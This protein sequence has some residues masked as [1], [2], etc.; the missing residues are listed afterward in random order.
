MCVTSTKTY[1]I[2]TE[3]YITS[4]ETYTSITSTLIGKEVTGIEAEKN[5]SIMDE[6]HR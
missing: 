4:T 3:T 2:P 5:S 1:I 6:E